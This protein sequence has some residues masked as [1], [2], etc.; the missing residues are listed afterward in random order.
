MKI[1]ENLPL[2]QKEAITSVDV[3]DL[4][5]LLCSEWVHVVQT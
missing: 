3:T 4:G 5:A 2:Y 1:R